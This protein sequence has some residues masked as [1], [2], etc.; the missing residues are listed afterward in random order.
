MADH[1]FQVL[2]PLE[3]KHPGGSLA[4]A[5]ARQQILLTMLLLHANQVVPVSRL[6]E[7]IWDD[8]PPSTALAQVRIC[9]CR[10][11]RAFGRLGMEDVIRTHSSGYLL[12]ATAES[13]DLVRFEE[14]LGRGRA[15]AASRRTAEAAALIRAALALW[16]GP[17]AGGLE[18]P[19][20]QALASR[21]NEEHA[22]ALEECFDLELQQG[23]HR[24]IIGELFVQVSDHP[25]RERLSAQLM[26]ALYRSDRQAEALEVYRNL[27]HRLDEDLGIEPGVALRRL[28]QGILAQDL[29]LAES[30]DAGRSLGP[31][32]GPGADA[33]P[34]ALQQAA[35]ATS[36]R[37][38]AR[39]WAAPDR[40]RDLL[41]Q[42]EWEN[43]WLRTSH[44]AR[45]HL[46]GKFGRV[47]FLVPAPVP[48]DVPVRTRSTAF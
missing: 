43:A 22:T 10:L 42:L 8:T 31:G 24:T 20:V 40:K 47:P 30:F 23:L 4:V 15:A 1:Q 3:V 35:V 9:V 18:S 44:A 46:L 34:A 17:A 11:R 14:L 5:G 33:G 29:R 7:A 12:Q 45:Q 19:L 27:R 6:V 41:H 38:T 21:V 39:P 25:Y 36:R 16:R 28:Q 37:P 26:L 13:F 2:G 32:P 48:A